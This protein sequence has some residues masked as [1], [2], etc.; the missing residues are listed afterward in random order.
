MQFHGSENFI[1]RENKN[2]KFCSGSN[3]FLMVRGQDVDRQISQR[4]AQLNTHTSSLRHLPKMHF[5]ISKH[6]AVPCILL[7]QGYPDITLTFIS[8]HQFKTKL[9]LPVLGNHS[10]PVTVLSYRIQSTSLSNAGGITRDSP[11]QSIKAFQFYYLVKLY[12]PESME[13]FILAKLFFLVVIVILE[14]VLYTINCSLPLQI[15]L[16]KPPS[17]YV[18]SRRKTKQKN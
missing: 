4:D 16:K 10:D 9:K 13:N 12:F 18:C 14:A 8:I 11:N 6:C 1:C 17:Y 15:S 7:S 5:N 3:A 2:I